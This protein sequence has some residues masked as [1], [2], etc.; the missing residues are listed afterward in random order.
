MP[1]GGAGDRPGRSDQRGVGMVVVVIRS[2]CVAEQS[3]P[4]TT[5]RRVFALAVVS[6]MTVAGLPL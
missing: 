4:T 2:V 5:T 1:G 6:T 3:G